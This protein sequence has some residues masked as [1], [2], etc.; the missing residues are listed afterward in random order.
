MTLSTLNGPDS[1]ETLATYGEVSDFEN[2]I[3][4]ASTEELSDVARILELNI[5]SSTGSRGQGQIKRMLWSIVQEL[6]SRSPLFDRLV[7]ADYNREAEA[8]S[9]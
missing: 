5:A 2:I 1:A 8:E 7:A 9:A 3:Y 6:E 4:S